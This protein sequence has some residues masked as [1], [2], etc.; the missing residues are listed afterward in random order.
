MTSFLSPLRVRLS[1]TFPLVLRSLLITLLLIGFVLG[2]WSSITPIAHA[3]SHASAT[4][5]T[6]TH[7]HS[8][9]ASQ[10]QQLSHPATSLTHPRT[11]LS[12]S[13]L[14]GLGNLRS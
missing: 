8:P 10:V 12:T 1:F 13:P 11:H 9:S 14:N 4:T 5:H 7:A 2:A 3:A 6:H